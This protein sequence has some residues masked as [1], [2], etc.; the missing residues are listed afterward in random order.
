MNSNA[1]IY[2]SFYDQRLWMDIKS[3]KKYQH[4]II[5]YI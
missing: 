1:K 5:K 4:I 3:S 2:V